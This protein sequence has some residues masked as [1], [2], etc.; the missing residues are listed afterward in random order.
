MELSFHLCPSHF[1]PQHVGGEF[2]PA[3]SEPFLSQVFQRGADVIH[4][5]VDAEEAVVGVLEHI[6]GDG[7]VLRI[8]ALQVEDELL[9]DVACVNMCTHSVVSLVEQG[10]HRVVHV[11]V[12]QDDAAFGAAHQVAD[13]SVGIEDLSV[14]EDALHGRQGH[15]D[16]KVDFLFRF[17][18]AL[19]QA[20]KALV[21]GITFEQIV[22]QHIVGPLAE[23]GGI[24]AVDTVANGKNGVEVVKLCL[25]SLAIRGS[26]FQNG[27]N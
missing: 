5:V 22:F 4:R 26:M 10:Q 16:E 25:I 27:T 6:D 19:L 21:D 18:Y 3:K 15:A 2:H 9:C 1:P 12:E 11:V 24:D 17:A 7:T 20:F 14:E 8:V 23:H 13:E